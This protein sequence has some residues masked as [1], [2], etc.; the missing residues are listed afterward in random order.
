[1]IEFDVP[2]RAGTNRNILTRSVVAAQLH[3][4][5]QANNLPAGWSG[6][7]AVIEVNWVAHEPRRLHAIDQF[8]GSCTTR[9]ECKSL[10]HNRVDLR[11]H[12]PR[13]ISPCVGWQL[14]NRF[15]KVVN[16]D[17]R[18][19]RLAAVVGAS[20]KRLVLKLPLD[21]SDAARAARAVASIARIINSFAER[22]CKFLRDKVCKIYCTVFNQ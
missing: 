17:C 8:V 12:I 4:A 21:A 10:H 3:V 9:G 13:G 5:E 18:K 2:I 16:G 6:S 11:R 20:G 14:A 19:R 22:K 1:M 7:H 15:G